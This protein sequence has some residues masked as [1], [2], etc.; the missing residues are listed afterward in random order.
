MEKHVFYMAFW[1][2]VL[3]AIHGVIIYSSRVDW[4]KSTALFNCK[5]VLDCFVSLLGYIDL[6]ALNFWGQ[7]NNALVAVFIVSAIINLGFTTLQFCF[8]SHQTAFDKRYFPLILFSVSFSMLMSLTTMNYC[9][10]FAFPNAFSM[11]TNLSF[12]EIAFEFLYYSFT[13]LLTYSSN[14]IEATSIL[15][16]S[17][18]MLEM[19][20]GYLLVG[21]LLYNLLDKIQMKRATK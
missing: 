4:N 16:K 11:P 3:F 14:S 15:G 20:L 2:L 10:Y 6:V 17:I 12:F 18:Q 9:L 1:Y 5:K 8:F 21:G 19:L 13:L 7:L